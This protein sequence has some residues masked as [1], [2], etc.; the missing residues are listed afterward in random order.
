METRYSA[1]R[2]ISLLYKLMSFMIVLACLFMIVGNV[3][4]IGNIEKAWIGSNV[5][6]YTEVR[7]LIDSV[8]ML[9]V[10]GF[11][12]ITLYAGGQLFD[13]FMD[14]EENTRATRA[15]MA[16]LGHILTQPEEPT[17]NQNR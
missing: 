8:L 14:I 13:L 6:R 16:R 12:S 4:R 5:Y 7:A 15:H 3:L 10:G 2:I 1:L 11:F 9:F 17:P